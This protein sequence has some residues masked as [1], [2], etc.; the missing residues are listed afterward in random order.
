ML[1]RMLAA[2]VLLGCASP[3]QAQEVT[4]YEL[5]RRSS[6]AAIDA[7]E[8]ARAKRAAP[9]RQGI[10]LAEGD[11]WFSYPGTDV[12]SELE[13]FGFEVE[14]DAT[15]GDTLENMAYNENEKERFRRKFRKVF[16]AG[17][18]A[19]VK[20]ILLSGG[21][22]DIAGPELGPLLNHRDSGR[23]VVELPLAEVV[24]KRTVDGL[25]RLIGA[26]DENAARILKRTDIPV[27][28]HAYAAAVPDGRP[29]GIGWPFPG[30]WLRPSFKSKDLATTSDGNQASTELARNT[31]AMAQLRN[32][33]AELIQ[34]RIKVR[35]W[36]HVKFVEFPVLTNN[37][38]KDAYKTTWANELHPTEAGFRSVAAAIAA[39]I[40]PK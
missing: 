13:E 34:E 32:R 22:N 40:L 15:A 18:A 38:V 30:P 3:A 2:V 39:V 36:T 26:V 37:L 11:S 6:G 29:F 17:R 33:Y 23:P 25:E 10:V 24:L 21:G 7:Y 16:Q 31:L 4:P 8:T 5:G 35:G 20:A 27:V 19:D 9:P 14:D 28:V 12:L 1:I